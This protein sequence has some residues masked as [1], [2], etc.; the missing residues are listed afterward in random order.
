MNGFYAVIAKPR[1]YLNRKPIANSIM[2]RKKRNN[3][4]RVLIITE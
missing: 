1:F 4:K 2:L 3:L